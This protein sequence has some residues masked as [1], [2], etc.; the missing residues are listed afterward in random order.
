MG[1][2]KDK[3][4]EGAAA[5]GFKLPKEIAGVKVPKA[6]RKQGEALIA[7]AQGPAGRE[8]MAAGLAVAAAAIAAK[9]GPGQAAAAKGEEAAAA[10]AGELRQT[11]GAMLNAGLSA[12]R[13]EL[14]KKG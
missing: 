2:K 6:L 3:P 14:G 4:A 9:T 5:P 7:H 11:F 8:L 10:A 12:F 1:K 13:S